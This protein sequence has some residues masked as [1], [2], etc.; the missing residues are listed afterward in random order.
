MFMRKAYTLNRVRDSFKIKEGN[1]TLSLYVDKDSRRIVTDLQKA[2]KQIHEI[3]PGSS[4]DEIRNASLAMPRAVFGEEQTQKIL[5]FYHNDVG[6]VA[7]IFGI[8]FSD[9]KNGLA[10]KITKAQKKAR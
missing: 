3:T 2:Q 7:T 6:C 4:E 10:K 8:Y 1:E 5:E 9:K